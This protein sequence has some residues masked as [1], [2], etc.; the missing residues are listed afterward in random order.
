MF[1]GSFTP[2]GDL[3]RPDIFS[4]EQEEGIFTENVAFKELKLP[5]NSQKDDALHLL[6]VQ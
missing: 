6:L 4:Q 2:A 1:L 3:R 5:T